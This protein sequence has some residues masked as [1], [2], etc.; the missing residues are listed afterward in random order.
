MSDHLKVLAKIGIARAVIGLALGAFLIWKAATFEA[1]DYGEAPP[2][3]EI[4]QLDRTVIRILGIGC[5]VLAP[6][7]AL[8]AMLVLRERRQGRVLGK[9]LALWD[10]VNLLL[11]PVS[12]ALGLYGFVV[13]RHPDTVGFFESRH[14]LPQH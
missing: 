10:M 13:Y 5:L 2:T 9:A 1:M 11:F 3:V 14:P 6:V 7:R 4:Q 12:T 8:Q